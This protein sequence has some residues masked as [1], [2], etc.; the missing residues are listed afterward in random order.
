MT[1]YSVLGLT[2]AATGEEITAAYRRLARRHHPDVN[3]AADAASKMRAINAAYEVLGDPVRRAAFDRQRFGKLVPTDSAE[4][5]E[6][7]RSWLA[8]RLDTAGGWRRVGLC[9]M[10]ASLLLVGVIAGSQLL[11]S[12]DPGEPIPLPAGT[13]VTVPPFNPINAPPTIVSRPG[14][15]FVT[16]DAWPQDGVLTVT[17]MTN[18]PDGSLLIIHLLAGGPG[19]SSE[20]SLGRGEAVVRGGRYRSPLPVPSFSGPATVQVLFLP[21][22]QSAEAVRLAVGSRGEHLRGPLVRLEPVA[23]VRYLR[24]EVTLLLGEPS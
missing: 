20:E 2:P 3:S 4:W 15:H 5:S 18:L 11:R 6:S 21:T 22:R 7:G 8:I 12:T 23:E 1:P 16:A 13:P 10:A 17:G 14:S 19:R 9:L 24:A